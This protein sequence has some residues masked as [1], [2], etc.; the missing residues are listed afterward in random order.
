MKTM[1]IS[2]LIP[3][4]FILILGITTY[5]QDRAEVTTT[6]EEMGEE[7]NYETQSDIV[8]YLSSTSDFSTLVAAVKAAD[9]VETLSG[10][11]PFTVFA[12]TNAAF[13]KVGAE[14]LESLLKPENVKTLK[15]IL[16]Y[17]VVAGILDANSLLSAVEKSGGQA[18]LESVSGQL[19]TAYVENGSVYVSD[20]SGNSVKIVDTDIKQTNGVI[21]VIEGVVMPAISQ[22]R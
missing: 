11:G 12:P 16:T 1:K 22:K 14:K 17:H 2:K 20:T 9:L 4:V 19:L 18:K 21:H 3:L 5:A 8:T 6:I 15:S 10:K 7:E 13:E